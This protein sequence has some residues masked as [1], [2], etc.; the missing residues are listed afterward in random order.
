[1]FEKPADDRNYADIL[2][3]SGYPGHQAANPPYD[4]RNPDAALSRLIKLIDHLF[5]GKRIHLRHNPCGLARGGQ[6][7]LFVDTL[8]EPLFQSLRRDQKSVVMIIGVADGDIS[9]KRRRVL[10]DRPVRGDDIEI[11]ILP[12]GTLVVI[13]RTQVRDVFDFSVFAE[14]YGNDLLYDVCLFYGGQG[15]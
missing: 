2:R 7:N 9:E 8:Q 5:I 11:G 6:L 13:S 12:A 3:L 15:Q 14:Q 1:M 4:Q 10:P